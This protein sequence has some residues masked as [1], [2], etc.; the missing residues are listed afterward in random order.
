MMNATS[1]TRPTTRILFVC[2]GNICRSPLAEGVVRERARALGLEGRVEVDSAGTG[3]WH[4]GDPPDPRMRAVARAYGVELTGKA[5]KVRTE[6]WYEFDHIVAMDRQN[7]ADLERRAP[8]G[9]ARAQ[10]HLFRSFE[11]LQDLDVPDPYYGGPEGFEAVFT[12]VHGTA[13]R[14]LRSLV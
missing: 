4:A 11:G 3:G 12:L 14:L 5:R 2:L 1:E 13:D 7:L 8:L 6:D 10:L 9:G